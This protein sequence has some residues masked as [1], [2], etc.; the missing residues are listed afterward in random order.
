[1]LVKNRYTALKPKNLH[2]VSSRS[3]EKNLVIDENDDDDDQKDVVEEKAYNF[4]NKGAEM[5]GMIF[6]FPAL[7]TL[8]MF[9]DKQ[10]HLPIEPFH[11]YKPNLLLNLTARYSAFNKISYILNVQN[12]SFHMIHNLTIA[13]AFQPL[14]FFDYSVFDNGQQSREI[15]LARGYIDF[16]YP[17]SSTICVLDLQKPIFPPFLVTF[18]ST[19]GFPA[20]SS[21]LSVMKFFLEKVIDEVSTKNINFM[22]LMK[23]QYS[24]ILTHFDSLITFETYKTILQ[25]S[26]QNY[27]TLF[28]EKVKEINDNVSASACIPVIAAKAI[29][30]GSY[31]VEKVYETFVPSASPRRSP[32]IGYLCVKNIFVE[33]SF[34]V[35]IDAKG[36]HVLFVTPIRKLTLCLQKE[37]QVKFNS[38]CL[39]GNHFKQ[40]NVQ[41]LDYVEEKE[42][43]EKGRYKIE[44]NSYFT[45]NKILGYLERK[46]V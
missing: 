5:D 2:F 17:G 42:M 25:H 35:S 3:S 12:T 21:S 4:E 16:L 40:C 45:F 10:D 18:S 9:T 13:V 7:K 41:Y 38:L 33:V 46:L 19:S 29:W 28:L 27:R 32:V 23:L 24:S 30:N 26:E 44:D 11:N 14:P 6:D 43:N 37:L 31:N 39:L 15:I 34:A 8:C 22:K 36:V 1:M 20:P